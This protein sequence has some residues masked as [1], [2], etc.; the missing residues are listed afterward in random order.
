M[1][2]KSAFISDGNK[3]ATF[4]WLIGNPAKTPHMRRSPNWLLSPRFPA[5]LHLLSHFFFVLLV[6]GILIGG[7]YVP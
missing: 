5:L 7:E 2:N 4:R 3:K 6:A 1:K